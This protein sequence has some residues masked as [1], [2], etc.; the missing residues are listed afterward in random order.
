MSSSQV[1]NTSQR[2]RWL[3]SHT[4]ILTILLI[5]SVGLNIF[6]ARKIN[7]LNSILQVKLKY[8]VLALGSTAPD[9]S[10]KDMS[11]KSVAINYG[12]NGQVTVLYVF[13]PDCHW[14][15]Q[16]IENIRFLAKNAGTKYRF[17]GISTTTDMLSEY[18][19]Q[20]TM[21]FEIYHSPPDTVRVA[22][23]LRATPSTIVVS[24]DGKILKY[25]QGAYS[26]ELQADVESFFQ[27]HLPGLIKPQS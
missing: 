10:A 20:N 7:Y 3:W 15:A 2:L 22:Y 25:W 11:D 19:A 12:E 21:P 5:G 9:L 14:C 17:V 23:N 26:N 4:F 16:N 13:S 18:L 1:P 27:V 24:S 8:P 6:L